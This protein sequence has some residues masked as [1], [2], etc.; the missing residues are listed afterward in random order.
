MAR[1]LWTAGRDRV[2]ARAL[3]KQAEAEYVAAGDGFKSELVKVR[4]W[5]EK[6]G[7]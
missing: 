1:A 3:A 4:A 5:L 6:H 7:R 2:R